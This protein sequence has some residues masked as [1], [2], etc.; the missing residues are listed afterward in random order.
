MRCSNG[1]YDAN[2]TN[3]GRPDDERRS[4]REPI[5]V[6]GRVETNEG[7]EDVW[8]CRQQ[9]GMDHA[10]AELLSEGRQKVGQRRYSLNTDLA[11]DTHPDSVVLRR[12]FESTH[13]CHVFFLSSSILNQSDCS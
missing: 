4:C 9:Q 2:N 13:S 10:E 8:R 3:Y 11:E 5:R 7:H 6:P 1:D 12:Q